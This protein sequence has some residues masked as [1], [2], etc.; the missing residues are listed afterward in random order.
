MSEA[1]YDIKQLAITTVDLE[2][3]LIIGILLISFTH[4]DKAWLTH[5]YANVTNLEPPLSNPD[6]NCRALNITFG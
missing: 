5:T 3:T 4:K 2:K 6:D 1:I